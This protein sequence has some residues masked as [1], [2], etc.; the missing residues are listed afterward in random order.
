MNNKLPQIWFILKQLM[1]MQEYRIGLQTT[2]L[3]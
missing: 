3:N 2:N 1:W